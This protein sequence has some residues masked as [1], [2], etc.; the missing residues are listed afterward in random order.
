LVKTINIIFTVIYIILQ[1]LILFDSNQVRGFAPI[2]API[3]MVECWNIGKMGLDLRPRFQ[4]IGLPA[5]G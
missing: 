2:G 4:P 1:F 5:G 3:G